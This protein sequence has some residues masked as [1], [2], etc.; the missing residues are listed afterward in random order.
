VHW[1]QPIRLRE[2]VTYAFNFLVI[3]PTIS[4]VITLVDHWLTLDNLVKLFER[5]GYCIISKIAR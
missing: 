1:S 3:D 4:F 2:P 5:R